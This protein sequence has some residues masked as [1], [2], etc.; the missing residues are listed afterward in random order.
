MG[1]NF[2]N[3]NI[4]NHQD[5]K[6]Y[7]SREIDYL[8]IIEA[9]GIGYDKDNTPENIYKIIYDY[10]NNTNKDKNQNYE[11]LI[12][13]IWF[14]ISDARF[15]DNEKKLFLNYKRFIKII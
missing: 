5:F 12:H 3:Q 6:L 11:N 7:S 1:N 4:N 15:F 8:K 2:L 14:C 9:K 13:C 10:I